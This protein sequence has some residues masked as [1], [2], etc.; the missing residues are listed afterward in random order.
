MYYVLICPVY[1]DLKIEPFFN[2]VHFIETDKFD[3][4][5]LKILPGL[6]VLFR[7]PEE[8]SGDK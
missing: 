4:G 7:C 2:L 3:L 1:H 5:L 6:L 8:R